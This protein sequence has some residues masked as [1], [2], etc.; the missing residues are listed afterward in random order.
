MRAA[1]MLVAGLVLA[2]AMAVSA[3]GETVAPE[4]S[5]PLPPVVFDGFGLD[6]FAGA[7]S[8]GAAIREAASRPAE[9]TP[10]DLVVRGPSGRGAAIDQLA[11]EI[12]SRIESLDVS[13]GVVATRRSIHDG[14]AAWTGSVAITSEQAEGRQLFEVR[15]SLTQGQQSGVFGI[16]VGPRLERRLP[17]GAMIFLDGKAE[18]KTQRSLETGGLL[19]PGNAA[20]GMVGVAARTGL[21]R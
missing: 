1:R 6:S 7:G 15:T 5:G 10:L 2:V 18:A 19:L 14:V 9:D 17:R 13:A 4:A 3:G 8:L 12:R 11:T 20:E 21:T 16:E